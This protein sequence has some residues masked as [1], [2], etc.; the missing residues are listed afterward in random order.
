MVFC[1]AD[2]RDA[3]PLWQSV[4][5][6]YDG[7]GLSLPNVPPMMLVSGRKPGSRRQQHHGSR[8]SSRLLLR[9]TGTARRAPL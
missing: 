9:F 5:A 1:F 4:L 7:L 3:Q 6:F 8:P 2:T